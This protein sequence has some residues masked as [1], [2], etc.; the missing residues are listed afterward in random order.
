MWAWRFLFLQ[1]S[2]SHS[3]RG[4]LFRGWRPSARFYASSKSLLAKSRWQ[5]AVHSIRMGKLHRALDKEAVDQL[6]RSSRKIHALWK[7]RF[8]ISRLCPLTAMDRL[9]EHRWQKSRKLVPELALKWMHDKYDWPWAHPYCLHL[10]GI[11]SEVSLK[12]IQES[13]I[14]CSQQSGNIRILGCRCDGSAYVQFDQ[15]TS[16]EAVIK[17]CTRQEGLPINCKTAIA[18][19]SEELSLAKDAHRLACDAFDVHP[20]AANSKK[21]SK[22]TK[23]LKTAQRGLCLYTHPR[24]GHITCSCPIRRLRSS[25][26]ESSIVLLSALEGMI[27]EATSLIRESVSKKETGE[28]EARHLR[29]IIQRGIDVSTQKA[30]AFDT[31]QTLS[32][33]RR[34]QTQCPVCFE[35]L[36]MGRDSDGMIMLTPCG[37]IFCKGC[38]QTYF[39]E[40]GNLNDTPCITCRKPL[41]ASDVKLIDPESKVDQERDREKRRAASK[42]VQEAAT[43]IRESNGHLEPRLWEAIYLWID[44]PPFVENCADSKFSAVPPTFLAHLKRAAGFNAT[45]EMKADAKNPE[46]LPS[47]FR[48]LVTDISSLPRREKVVVFASSRSAVSAIEGVLEYARLGCR[49]LFTGQTESKSGT[50]VD[51][52]KSLDDVRV[53]VVQTGAAACGLTLTAASKMFIMEPLMKLEEEKQAY[54][55]LHRYGQTREVF[56]KV[57]YTPV[58]VESRLLDWR[59]RAEQSSETMAEKISYAPLRCKSDEDATEEHNQT[60]FLLGMDKK[61]SF[62]TDDTISS[63]S[64]DSD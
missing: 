34:E 35:Q 1:S 41:K 25:M 32:S 44:P 56:C 39:H 61:D 58:S 23:R 9:L 36:G 26:P 30:S 5:W 48:A 6:T 24:K 16:Y 7:W 17:A 14:S 15:K 33:G 63:E 18:S 22:A 45:S 62:I 57:Y 59:R 46:R 20:C 47:K 21:K 2:L 27:V 29:S 40:R 51:E 28:R 8:L 37:H 55:R 60:H 38:L 49:S 42:L 54:A 53:L 12:E 11:P 31:L 10:T 13:L 43:M 50:A 52:W 3:C 19:V 64:S 4:F